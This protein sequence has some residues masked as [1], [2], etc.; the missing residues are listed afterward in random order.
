MPGTRPLSALRPSLLEMADAA[1]RAT[2]ETVRKATIAVKVIVDEKG[3]K[4]KIRS[5]SGK[6][7]PLSGVADV[8]VFG[9]F[10]KPVGVVKGIPEGFW[11]LVEYGSGPHLIVSN[12]GRGGVGRIT[13]SGRVA[14][15][16]YTP[17]QV[18][19][20][21]GNGDSLGA[22]Q[23]LR[24]PYG[25]RQFVNHPGHRS[26]AHP[27]E[28]SMALAPAVVGETLQYEQGK[29]LIRAFTGQ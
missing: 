10:N 27:W 26:I 13:R 9:D 7:V 23:P 4:Y 14:K 24:T 28:F 11:A 8:K 12:K 16:F 21:L 20:R 2:I 29:A 18:M 3:G 22:L 25:P 6:K 5:R 19:R 1:Q 17:S 15:R